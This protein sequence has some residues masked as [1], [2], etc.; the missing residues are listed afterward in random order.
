VKLRVAIMTAPRI[1]ARGR[2]G[3]RDAGG[4]VRAAGRPYARS[5]LAGAGR[6]GADRPNGSSVRLRRPHGRGPVAS[7]LPGDFRRRGDS[8]RAGRLWHGRCRV[9]HH[10]RHDPWCH[11]QPSRPRHPSAC[12]G[13]SRPATF[14]AHPTPSSW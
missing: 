6:T 10:P 12:I 5:S 13:E 3:G 9:S 2:R 8:T 7:A 11:R 14:S 4:G 1:P